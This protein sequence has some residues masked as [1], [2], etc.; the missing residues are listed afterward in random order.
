MSR[1]RS[2]HGHIDDRE[3][4]NKIDRAGAPERHEQRADH[5]GAG[6]EQVDAGRVFA[7]EDQEDQ[8]PARQ[9]AVP[10]QRQRDVAYHAGAAVAPMVRA[11]SSSSGPTCSSVPEIS[12]MP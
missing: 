4:R 12:R 8:Q 1:V 9:H 7:H 10:D 2:D 11:A 5:F 3:R 6:A